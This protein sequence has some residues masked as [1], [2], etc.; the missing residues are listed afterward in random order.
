MCWLFSLI[1]PESICVTLNPWFSQDTLTTCSFL[2]LFHVDGLKKSINKYNYTFIK[3]YRFF[4]FIITDLILNSIN[5]SVPALLL[6]ST[7][8]KVLSEQPSQCSH[9]WGELSAFKGDQSWWQNISLWR[10][11]QVLQKFQI[12]QNH[13]TVSL[14]KWSPFVYIQLLSAAASGCPAMKYS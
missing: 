11:S 5:F 9:N 12:H 7:T 4:N 3:Y 2:Y 6:S 14:L 10:K 1:D 8:N 13:S